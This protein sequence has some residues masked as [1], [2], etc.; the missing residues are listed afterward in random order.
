[1]VVAGR[2]YDGEEVAV[3]GGEACVVAGGLGEEDLGGKGAVDAEVVVVADVG[4]V[5]SG[6]LL[7]KVVTTAAHKGLGLH[8]DVE[9]MAADAGAGCRAYRQAAVAG[10]PCGAEGERS[11]EGGEHNEA[12]RAEVDYRDDM[13]VPEDTER[14][15]RCRKEV[16]L[17]ERWGP[18]SR[19]RAEGHGCWGHRG[20]AAEGSLNAS[21]A[22]V[23]AWDL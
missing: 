4:V 20:T 18:N 7:A 2:E 14:D 10:R 21:M 15:G 22:N 5:G 16:S 6:K 19:G 1:M 3:L 23:A 13:A 8:A 9:D 17:P 12:A 11:V